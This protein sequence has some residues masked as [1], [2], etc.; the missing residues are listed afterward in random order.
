MV[1]ALAN[2]TPPKFMLIPG[3]FPLPGSGERSS[4]VS[5]GLLKPI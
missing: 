4:T 3:A 1:Q 2:L 5:P